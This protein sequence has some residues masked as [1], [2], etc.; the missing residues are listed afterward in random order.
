MLLPEVSINLI[1]VVQLRLLR[2]IRPEYH[3]KLLF[4]IGLLLIQVLFILIETF[5]RVLS[6]VL[7]RLILA[8]RGQVVCNCFQVGLHFNDQLCSILGHVL[9]VICGCLCAFIGQSAVHA[10]SEHII[11]PFLLL[12]DETFVVSLEFSIDFILLL[13]CHRLLG[14]L[15]RLP[16]L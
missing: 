7:S 15:S 12:C 14:H 9:P 10:E 5:L 4:C 6:E 11:K 13:S 3:I 2:L 16:L 1:D 8:F